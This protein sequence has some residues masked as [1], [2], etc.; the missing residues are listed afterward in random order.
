L[1]QEMIA[2]AQE[3]RAKVI[4]AEVKIPLAIAN[5]FESG[6]LGIMDYYRFRNIEADT[7]MRDSFSKPEDA[8][9]KNQDQD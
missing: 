2:K 1:E 4:E 6:N 7:K 3:A 5:A 9:G 8:A